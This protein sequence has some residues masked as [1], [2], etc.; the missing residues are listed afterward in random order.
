MNARVIIEDETEVGP[1][2]TD[3]EI[4]EVERSI[5]RARGNQC[6]YLPGYEALWLADCIERATAHGQQ[7]P[8]W[9]TLRPPATP[10]ERQ[11]NKWAH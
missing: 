7:K 1:P 8:H 11:T 5:E 2:L 4:A 6:R 9:P 3:H 10:E